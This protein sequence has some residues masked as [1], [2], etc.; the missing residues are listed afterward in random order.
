MKKKWDYEKIMSDRKIFNETVYTTLSQAIEI[1]E[2]RQK[3]TKLREKIEKIL[4]NNIPEPLKEGKNAVQFRQIATPNHDTHWFV[5][6]TRDN[7]LKTVFFEYHSD[8]FTSNNDFKHSL[9]QL[10]IHEK[11]NKK[12]EFIEEKITILDFNKYNGEKFKNVMTLWS[13]PL[14]DF[15][16]KLFDICGYDNKE[17]CFFD[18]SEWFKKNGPKA[19]DYYTNFLLL[20]ICHGILFENF[21][22]NGEEGEFTKKILLPALEKATEL[23]GEKPLIVPIPPMDNELDAHW[24]SYTTKIKKLIK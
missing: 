3:D 1:L 9:G 16:R 7:K 24:V 18:A 17:L 21:L 5:E 2:Q 15:H 19:I 13:E 22:L 6:L 4:D 11:I 8:K 14:V 23:A 20:F 10:R 12:G